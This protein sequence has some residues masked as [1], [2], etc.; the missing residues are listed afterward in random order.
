[1]TTWFI[2]D[3]HFGGQPRGRVKGSGM[4]AD[5]LDARMDTLWRE[6]IADDDDVWHLGDIGPDM[7]RLKTLPGRKYVIQGNADPSLKALRETGLFEGVWKKHLL[8][9]DGVWLFLVHKPTDVPA[10]P[11]GQVVHGHL[12][13]EAPPPGYCSV[14]V[15]RT[16]WGP[17]TLA[18][19][20]AR[21]S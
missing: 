19:L 7:D 5:A 16:G 10:E 1:M 13:D 11:G 6:R 21:D 8:E 15:D 18:E 9:I 3:T 14:S 17:M 12:H 4:S 2:A 20:L